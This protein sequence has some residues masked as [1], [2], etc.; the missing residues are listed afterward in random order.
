[1][2][3]NSATLEEFE[4]WRRLVKTI[5]SR[6]KICRHQLLGKLQRPE[7]AK[8]ISRENLDCLLRDYL[9]SGGR[10]LSF[11]E[12]RATLLMFLP[13]KIREE[14]FC[15]FQAMQEVAGCIF[16]EDAQDM[17]VIKLKAHAQ[18]QAEFMVQ[19]S[20][21]NG[22]QDPANMLG[23]GDGSYGVNLYGKVQYEEQY[24]QELFYGAKGWKGKGAK[25]KGGRGEN[26]G[27]KS[28]KGKDPGPAGRK[29]TS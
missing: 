1:M 20:A 12:R 18:R 6:C 28:D 9:E 25:G 16:S 8:S 24:E 22:R 26:K 27:S 29:A 11:E 4:L 5:R 3:N 13:Q 2:H 15:R 7:A 10:R 23:G 14:M 19:W 17:A 21:M